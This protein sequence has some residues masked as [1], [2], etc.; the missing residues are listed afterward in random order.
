[1]VKKELLNLRPLLA[2][3]QMM[4]LAKQDVLKKRACTTQWGST[5]ISKCRKYQTFLRCRFEA[6]ILKI[7]VFFPDSMRLGARHPAYEI[8]IDPAARKFLTYDHT[9]EKWRTAK[10]NCLDLPGNHG[11]QKAAYLSHSDQKCLK[12]V[13]KLTSGDFDGIVAYQESIR[14]DELLQR[15]QRKM[16]PWDKDMALT[17]A[18]PK[19]WLHWVDKVGIPQQYIFYPY[20]KSG[21]KTGYCSYCEKDVT[22]QT[23]PHH[24][25][26]GRCPCCHHEV[27]FKSIGRLPHHFF[28]ADFCVYL[29]QKRPDGMMIREFWACRSY[30]KENYKSPKLHCS[31]QVRHLYDPSLQYRTYYWGDFKNRG[32]R[33]IAGYPNYSI[34]GF[35]PGYHYYNKGDRDGRVYGKTI[36][37]LRKGILSRTGLPEWLHWNGMTGNPMRYLRVQQT[38]PILEQA[39]KA[40]LPGLAAEWIQSVSLMEQCV[41]EAN[42]SSLVQALG[43]DTEKLKR[44][45]KWNGGNSALLWLQFEKESMRPIS[46]ETILWFCQ[47]KVTPDNLDFILERM[48]PLQICNYLKRQTIDCGESVKQILIT[49]RD[50]LSMAEKLGIDTTDEI[51]YRAKKLQLRHDELVLRS[52]QENCKEPAL[53]VLKS[54]PHVDEICQ[55]LQ[56]KYEYGDKDYKIVAPTGVADILAEGKMLCHCVGRGDVYWDRISRH[57]TY[58]LF[59][60]KASAPQVPYYTLEIEPDGTVRQKRTKFDRQ[61][62]DI[63]QATKF[64]KKW[65]RVVASR[66]TTS[67]RQMAQ[68]SRILREQEFEDL[69]KKDVRIHTGDLHG[70]RLVDVLTADLLESEQ[71]A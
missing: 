9:E 35:S 49:W 50:Y 40:Q 39:V 30:S 56:E 26:P 27:I 4:K 63:E 20:K 15:Y 68:T 66:I 29:P 31:E 57:E 60:R 36:P 54:F 23:T 45:R 17:P 44:L 42:A 25:K 14:E 34:Y 28:T 64:L 51:V 59:L 2:T 8:F 5:Y 33:W 41:Q 32:L 47:Q 13:L 12:N 46:D 19:D 61:E 70:H 22:L 18:L 69:R 65:Q 7:A 48:S 52:I 67:D 6:G 37:A 24:N 16:A 1:M 38:H 10:L 43:I 71:A 3:N 21:T 58:L 62:A 11:A 55:T 53:E